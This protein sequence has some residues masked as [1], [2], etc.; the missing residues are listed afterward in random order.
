MAVSN[1]NELCRLCLDSSEMLYRLDSDFC[2][3]V[4]ESGA[5][6]TITDALNYLSMDIK[7]IPEDSTE[8]NI[9]SEDDETDTKEDPE[10]ELNLP[11]SLC[12]ECLEKLQSAYEFK[13]RCEE[14]RNFLRNYVRECEDSKKADERAAREAAL[15]ALDLD[16]DNISSLPDK[17]VL[18]QI[19]KEKKPRKP[20]DPTKPP[21][22]RRRRVLEKNVIIAED[23]Q[24][25][26]G[27]Y[28]RKLI[29]TPEQSPEQ[30]HASKRKSKHVIIEDI[31]VDKSKDKS[32]KKDTS[33]KHASTKENKT[34]SGETSESTKTSQDTKPDD[35]PIFEDDEDFEDEPRKQSKRLK[36]IL[37][38][39][40][41]MEGVQE[42]S[43]LCRICL[44]SPGI[45]IPFDSRVHFTLKSIPQVIKFCLD[46]DCNIVGGD[47]L[48]KSICQV[49]LEKLQT[50]Y[51]IKSKGKESEKYLKD[52]LLNQIES[53]ETLPTYSST[54]RYDV[55]D[56]ESL[57]VQVESPKN[58]DV[59]KLLSRGLIR[60]YRSL[61]SCTV[62]LKQF[63]YS[64]P[65]LNHMMLHNKNGNI[66]PAKK[67][68]Q[69]PYDS[70]SPYHSPALFDSNLLE[71]S[72]V[73]TSN[74]TNDEG[75]ELL[76][77]TTGYVPIRKG[78]GRRQ[79]FLKSLLS[80]SHQDGNS[81]SEFN[82]TSIAVYE[83]NEESELVKDKSE[84]RVQRGR[85]RPR[86]IKPELLDSLKCDPQ[87]GKSS[88]DFGEMVTADYMNDEG[89]ELLRETTGH[90]SLV[91]GRGRPPKYKNNS[92]GS[93]KHHV[94]NEESKKRGRGRPR[95][96]EKSNQTRPTEHSIPSG[97]G[98]P[99]T[100]FLDS[101]EEISPIKKEESS[102]DTD[103]SDQ[104][105]FSKKKIRKAR[106]I[107]DSDNSVENENAA[108]IL[109]DFCEVDV[110][111][112]LEKKVPSFNSVAASA[113]P[114]RSRSRSS[115]VELIQEFD[116]FGS[117]I[118]GDSSKTGSGNTFA[119]TFKGCNRKFH[120]RA[121]M[122][123]HL[124][125]FHAALN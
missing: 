84:N 24:V 106:K 43:D 103:S 123:K 15:I 100:K 49:C 102:S 25:E 3:L 5:S 117:P 108:S 119:C 38:R 125:E 81:S 39:D 90:V 89:D 55:S 60:G 62:C 50:A 47:I 18:K 63:K 96:Y 86:K 113:Q 97:R 93:S 19:K 116:I 94:V 42:L 35:E 80:D 56:G 67:T 70:V 7:I 8:E 101:D 21:V 120:L 82:D 66:T 48:P 28:V 20:R 31:L 53:Q 69:S 46:I 68:Q 112:V 98:R 105:S 122:N 16:I 85:G 71:S 27:A 9:K 77:E 95:K 12:Q 6:V 14:N 88:P 74:Y 13:F 92:E 83:N 22:V 34:R 2:I 87:E 78:S 118:S 124:R 111:K 76:S 114:T 79:K 64:K 72:S 36:I 115:S 110:N 33:N 32:S 44:E 1:M 41:K 99:R 23:S 17:L 54:S 4:M 75:D 40:E 59:E 30:K 45:L 52:I 121:N 91:R 51:E 10:E 29:T 104:S 73:E 26:T 65:F 107:Q 11:K 109:A 61:F 37:C 57:L 58:G